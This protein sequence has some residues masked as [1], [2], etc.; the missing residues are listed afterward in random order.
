MSHHYS[1][2]MEQ[3]HTWF[4]LYQAIGL[5]QGAGLHHTIQ[6]ASMPKVRL[7]KRIWW[8]CIIR[9]RLVALGTG[10]P[11][12]IRNADCSTAMI[13]I[14]DLEE[15]GDTDEQRSI[16][17]LFLDFSRL[18]W[19]M[20]DVITATASSISPDYRDSCITA[21]SDWRRSLAQPAQYQG[22]ASNENKTS[23]LYYIVT[24]MIYKCVSR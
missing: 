14:M 10:R 18:C 15:A 13:D 5:A 20:D 7:W 2:M 8:A 9:D 21:L 11:T 19:I 16:K 23:T 22:K 24:Q 6:K 1:S 3:K 12:H 17:V 4:W